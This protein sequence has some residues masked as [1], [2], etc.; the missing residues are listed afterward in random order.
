M[1]CDDNPLA[2]QQPDVSNRADRGCNVRVVI[3][4]DHPIVRKRIRARLTLE[5]DIEVVGEASNGH[6]VIDIAE[7]TDPDVVILDLRMPE[8]DGITALKKLQQRNK[9]LKI[10]LLTTFKD[11]HAFVL[12]ANLGYAGIVLKHN[13]PKLIVNC[14]RTVVAGESWPCFDKPA[15]VANQ[16]HVPTV[17]TGVTSGIDSHQFSLSPRQ[18]EIVSL[19]AQGYKNREIADQMFVSEQTVKNHLHAIFI[20]SGVSGRLE[21]ALYAFE[22]GLERPS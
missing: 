1:I 7:K 6:E 21:L 3:A 17:S 10:I 8:M 13:A 11:K 14:I 5:A 16:R 18:R 4:D 22:K 12:A 19:V 9:K 20:K 2:G 15:A